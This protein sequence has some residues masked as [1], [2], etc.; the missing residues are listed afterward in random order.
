MQRILGIL[1]GLA[2]AGFAVLAFRNAAEGWA[3][4]HT[5]IGLWFTI[6]AGFLSVAATTAI[7]GTILHTRSEG[8]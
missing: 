3:A 1:A 5:D 6:I 4:G 7:V 2:I 8:G